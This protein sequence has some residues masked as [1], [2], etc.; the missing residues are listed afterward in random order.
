M[1]C[2]KTKQT[3]NQRVSLVLHFLNTS[4]NSSKRNALGNHFSWRAK[5]RDGWWSHGST[6]WMTFL[7]E[8][9]SWTDGLLEE[10]QQLHV[11]SH[12]GETWPGSRLERDGCRYTFMVNTH[13]MMIT[14]VVLGAP[15]NP[16]SISLARTKRIFSIITLMALNS[17]MLRYFHNER[18][19]L[20][21]SPLG[22]DMTQGQFLSGVFLLLD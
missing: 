6:G 2:R 7:R 10:L 14:T 20:P 3:T 15:T 12:I 4:H 8:A 22:Q 18:Y 11:H 19:Y 16:L 13:N 17:S 1:I 21:T 5:P 9:P